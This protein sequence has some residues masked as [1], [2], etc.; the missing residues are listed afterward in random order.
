MYTKAKCPIHLKSELSRDSA[1]ARAYFPPNFDTQPKSSTSRYEAFLQ[2]PQK[3]SRCLW[4]EQA[5]MKR[6]D[7]YLVE[8][9]SR[10]LVS[11]WDRSQ[12]YHHPY[13]WDCTT[14]R[15]ELK[16]CTV[17]MGLESLLDESAETLSLKVRFDQEK[18]AFYVFLWRC[19]LGQLINVVA[20][21]DWA[22]CMMHAVM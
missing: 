11:I 10:C 9:R 7:S 17:R 20:E 18:Q 21:M 13:H 4:R 19:Y 22:Q 6:H 5:C 2:F 15:M 1:Q 16:K 14:S 3:N 8:R 12:R